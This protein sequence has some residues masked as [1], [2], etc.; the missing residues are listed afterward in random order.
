MLVLGHRLSR[1][2]RYETVAQAMFDLWVDGVVPH[3][4]E[5]GVGA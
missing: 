2:P 3:A 5:W 1:E 4:V